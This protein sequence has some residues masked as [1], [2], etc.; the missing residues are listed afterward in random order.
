M[1]ILTMVISSLVVGLALASDNF[2]PIHELQYLL[3]NKRRIIYSV[4]FSATGFVFAMTAIVIAVIEGAL[5]YD[6]QGFVMWSAL[7]S[8]AIWL[9]AAAVISWI[10]SR[11]VLPV[12][13]AQAESIFAD[14][15]KQLGVAE[16]LEIWLKQAAQPMPQTSAPAGHDIRLNRD[17][18]FEAVQDVPG[19]P[20]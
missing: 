15:T 20:H 5:Q 10:G 18:D 14:I 16:L 12:R 2:S 1:K 8:A 7:F 4:F 6:A 17:H 3:A 11:L 9:A 19:Y 13:P